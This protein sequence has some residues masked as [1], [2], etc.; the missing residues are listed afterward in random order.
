VTHRNVYVRSQ[1]AGERVLQ[2][3]RKIYAR[4]QLSVNEEKTAVGTVFG[5]KFLG[6]CLRRWSGNTVKIAPAPLSI[7]TFKQRIRQLTRRIGGHSLSRVAEDLRT[8]VP[9][10][11]AYFGLART[12]QIFKDLD[13]WLRRRLRAIQLKHWR[14]GTTIYNGLRALGAPHSLATK[15][16]GAGG[17]WWHCS[18]SE[19]HRVL[20]VEY[21]DSL[22]IPRVS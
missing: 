2:A 21:F 19:L 12:P 22:G 6:F 17:R 10:W 11:K 18:L 9:G 8:Y 15:V 13:S 14:R 20:S 1:K 7:E 5:R 16:A 4:L 3:L